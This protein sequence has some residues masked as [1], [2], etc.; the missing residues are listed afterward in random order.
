MHTGFNKLI[1]AM[2]KSWTFVQLFL[3]IIST[4]NQ[5]VGYPSLRRPYFLCLDTKKVSKEK[6]RILEAE[7]EENQRSCQ[8]FLTS[9][10]RIARCFFGPSRMDFCFI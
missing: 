9:G 10:L 8:C 6:S 5:I 7:V 1:K 3:R 4:N 2:E